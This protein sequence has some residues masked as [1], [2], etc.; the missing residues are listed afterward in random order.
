MTEAEILL[1]RKA[2]Q[3]GLPGPGPDALTDPTMRALSERGLIDYDEE[4]KGWWYLSDKG[5]AAIV[6]S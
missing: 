6:A 4:Q 5:R 1:L 3:Q 2:K